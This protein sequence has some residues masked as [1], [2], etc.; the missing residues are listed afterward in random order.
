M[1][2]FLIVLS[3]VRVR[4]DVSYSNAIIIKGGKGCMAEIKSLEYLTKQFNNV[5][6]PNHLRIV[7][8]ITDS[9]EACVL[10]NLAVFI[11][12]I[13]K[14][15]GLSVR[16][17]N[18]RSR[19][20]LAVINDLEKARSMPRVETLIRLGLA[21]EIDFNEVFKALILP[22]KISTDINFCKINKTDLAMDIAR[23]GY[24]KNQVAEIL[25]FI[26][27]IDFKATQNN[28]K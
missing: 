15:K 2:V 28:K 24:D 23:Y 11:S 25:D 3:N 14:D 22:D 6:D 7:S 1:F 17:L 21:L 27:Y 16:E 19:V 10:K 18:E 5:K 20:S 12:T 8:E 9:L 26:K 4:L 13:R